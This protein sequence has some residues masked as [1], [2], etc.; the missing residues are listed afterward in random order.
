MLSIGTV[1]SQA[2]QWIL[3]IALGWFILEFT[4]SALYVGLLG[5]AAGIPMILASV[6]AG[7][8]LDRFDRRNILIACQFGM[9]IVGIWLFVAV[10][11]RR[12]DS[13][14]TFLLECSAMA[15]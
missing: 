15:D 3:N 14:A 10:V 7:I 9:F 13:D 11:Y 2:G 6:P 8:V 5:F 12:C 4:D 1:T